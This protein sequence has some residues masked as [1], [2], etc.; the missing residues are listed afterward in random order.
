MI[1][2]KEAKTRHPNFYL[3]WFVFFGAFV[4]V[5]WWKG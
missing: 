4:D 1:L 5:I 3:V 2:E